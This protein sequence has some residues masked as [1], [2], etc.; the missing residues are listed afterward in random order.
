[1]S[2]NKARLSPNGTMAGT[3][4]IVA[5]LWAS[6]ALAAE[7]EITDQAVTDAVEDQILMDHAVPLTGI[8]VNTV[9]GIVNLSGTVTNALAQERAARIAETVKGVRAVVN[10][11]EVDPVVE[12]SDDTI[13]RNVENA[14]LYNPATSSYEIDVTV[15]DGTVT[16][17]GTVDSWQEQELAKKEARG[18]QG[19]TNVIDAINVDYE[20]ERPDFE[21]QAEIQQALR[22]DILIDDALIDVQ[23]DDGAVTLEGTV[24]SAAEKTR[25]MRTAWIA[26]VSSMDAE[27]LEVARWA[28]DEDLR[29]DKF[30]VKPDE[31]VEAAIEEALLYDPRV[32]STNVTPEVSLGTAT[33]RGEVASV[34]ARRAA[35][36]TASNTVGVTR[37]RNRLRVSPLHT[38]PDQEIEENVRAALARDP[39]VDRFDV[40]VNVI[41][42]TAYLY[43]TVDSYF[44]KAQADD[45]AARAMGVVAVDN[46]LTVR[47]AHRPYAEDPYLDGWYTFDY[48]WHDY[49]PRRTKRPD[50]EIEEDIESQLWWSPFVSADDVNVTV[51]DGTAIL[52]GTVGSWSEYRAAR[53]NAFD[54]G[55]VWVVNNLQVE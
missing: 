9:N 4:C 34:L 8:H 19:V 20:T 48:D 30:V 16:L 22:W 47:R 33:L 37:V 3:L 15:T 43:G 12:I 2:A 26:G 14:L 25:A 27:G 17:A 21:I 53:K 52:T 44:E 55:A 10:R 24:G 28:R 40:T 38:P 51:E 23:V 1:M 54:G 42:G 41:N 50:S 13:R 36:D 31:E 46:N 49:E 35:A 39:Y 11:L 45:V 32:L 29:E 7:H 5:L 18:V 6:L